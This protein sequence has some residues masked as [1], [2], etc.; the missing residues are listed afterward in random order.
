M[1]A[2]TVTMSPSLTKAMGPPTY[3]S[4]ATW[5]IMKP[6]VAPEKRP[7]VNSTTLSSSFWPTMAPVTASISRIPG[8]PFGPS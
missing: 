3:A 5:P 7:S 1:S 6:W 8:P 2:S 4:G